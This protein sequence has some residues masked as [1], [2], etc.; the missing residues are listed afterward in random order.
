MG[1]YARVACAAKAMHKAANSC[2]WTRGLCCR[3]VSD[4]PR[5]A[6]ARLRPSMAA[7]SR[8]RKAFRGSPG[9]MGGRNSR[10]MVPGRFRKLRRRQNRPELRATGTRSEEHTSELQS[11]MRI[12][13]AVFCLKKKTKVHKTK[14]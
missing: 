7:S 1:E 10:V 8:A 13:Y 12:S 11:L 9:A 2:C 5:P 14:L 4:R 6:R 3:H